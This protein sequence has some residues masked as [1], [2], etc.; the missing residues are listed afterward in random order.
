[1]GVDYSGHYGIGQQIKV[2]DFEENEK[3]K[4]F[5]DCCTFEEYLHELFETEKT[6]CFS[7]FRVGEGSYTGKQDKFFIK[8]A[9]AFSDGLDLT[10][11]KE[12]FDKFIQSHNFET[13]GEF[14]LIGGLEVW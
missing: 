7:Y 1:M 10:K 9:D 4:G 8:I 2:V 11:Q 6:R 12:K 13:I 5:E 3:P 14:G